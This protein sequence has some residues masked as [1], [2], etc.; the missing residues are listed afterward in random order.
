MRKFLDC[1]LTVFTICGATAMLTSCSDDNDN[2]VPQKALTV[3]ELESNLTGLQLDI[4]DYIMGDDV[5]RVL[6]LQSGHTGTTYELYYD[7]NNEFQIDTLHCS[8]NGFI[9]KEIQLDEETNGMVSGISVGYDSEFDVAAG[10]DIP[11][12]DMYVFP[13]G[14]PDK[15]SD[16]SLFFINEYAFYELISPNSNDTRTRTRA[17]QLGG[18]R[19]AILNTLSQ[20]L[21]SGVSNNDMA[22]KASAEQFFKT[23]LSKLSG[24]SD[25]NLYFNPN[26]GYFTADNWR[27]QTSIYL[28]DGVGPLSQDGFRFTSVTL[29]WSQNMTNSNL[30]FGFCDNITPEAGWQLVLNYCGSTIGVNTNYFALYNRYS[31]I[32]RFFFYM[33]SDFRVDGANDHAWKVVLSDKLLEHVNMRYSLPMDRNITNR[34]AIGMNDADGSIIVSPWVSSRSTDHYVTPKAGWWAFDIDLSLYRPNFRSIGEQVRLQ[35][36][37]W[38]KDAATLSSTIDA[39]V[40]EKVEATTYSFNSL[41]GIG[42]ILSDGGGALGGVVTGITSANWTDAAKS[43]LNLAKWGYNLYTSHRDKDKAPS[44]NVLQYIDGTIST[45]GLIS[46]SRPVSG[47]SEP[48]IPLTLFD[49]TNTT[50]GQGIWNLKQTPVLYQVDGGVRYNYAQY[51]PTDPLRPSP[52]TLFNDNYDF[53]CGTYCFFDPS[54]VQVELN[55]NVFP[56]S[57]VEYMDV[58]SF[59]GVRKGTAHDTNDNYRQAFGMAKNEAFAPSATPI[60]RYHEKNSPIDNSNP[61]YDY[62]YNSDDKLGMAAPTV[63]TDYDA[64]DDGYKFGLVGR[65]NDEYLLEPVIFAR[66]DKSSDT[67]LRLPCY[68]VTVVLTVKLKGH[69]EPFIYTRTYIPEIKLLSMNNAKSVVNQLTQHIDDVKKNGKPSAAAGTKMLEMQLAHIKSAMTYL[70]SDYESVLEGVTYT[71]YKNGGAYVSYLFDGNLTTAWESHIKAREN[72][73]QWVFGF[74]ASKPIAPKKYTLITSHIW[75]EY[76]GSNPTL[77]ALYGW[78]KSGHWVQIDYRN[79]EPGMPDALPQGNSQSKTYTIQNPGTFEYFQM[80]IVNYGGS[81]SGLAGFWNPEACRCRIA[82]FRFE[83]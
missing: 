83:D 15:E 74:Q 45:N 39:K 47:F 9:D 56:S 18:E 60:F 42:A 78:D 66:S 27:Q 57:E 3:E 21:S 55:P 40:K 76:Q 77:W 67:K 46:G 29:P 71:P 37:A 30:P 64:E 52:F 80:V 35:M 16:L 17:S 51:F 49:V 61:L 1:M 68:E 20:T 50:L 13:T 6:D 4:S 43:G 14:D 26:D 36:C 58:Q 2:H 41:S 38:Q 62:L 8:W 79:A 7:D 22:S 53:Y 25:S 10:L 75:S 72:G 48:T 23:T 73:Q 12:I 70:K 11:N 5:L 19:D 54:S 82:E 63:Y 28:Y 59:C 32:L 81:L 44:Y 69:Q 31:G 24:A 33:P 34:A 65:G